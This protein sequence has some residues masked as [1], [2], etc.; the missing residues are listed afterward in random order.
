MARGR[1][2]RTAEKG[3]RLLAKLA[4]G[5]SVTAAC[6]VEGI[7]RS[8]YY[9]WRGADPVFAK[10]ADEAIESGTDALEDVAKKR[11]TAPEGGSDTLL[12]FLL[13]AR[14]PEKYRERSD[15]QVSGSGGGPLTV[16]IGQRSDGPQ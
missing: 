13:K 5:Y 12:I 1:T 14:R 8:A 6:K 9:D 4:A 7:G 15:I 11:A 16:V 10:A 3:E 2:N